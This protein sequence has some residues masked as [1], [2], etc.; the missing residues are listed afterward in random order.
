LLRKDIEV[1]GR[2]EEKLP[3]LTS[4]MATDELID[5]CTEVVSP[6]SG[7][8]KALILF[9]SH[10]IF[11]LASAQRCKQLQSHLP[12]NMGRRRIIK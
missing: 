1:M 8:Q 4:T 3:Y 10:T 6:S 11:S 2:G 9:K 12:L 7:Q 5:E